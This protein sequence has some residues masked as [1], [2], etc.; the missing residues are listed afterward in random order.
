MMTQTSKHSYPRG[1]CRCCRQLHESLSQGFFKA[2]CDENRLRL[3]VQLAG[4]RTPCTVSQIAECC[5]VDLSVVS[6]HLAVLRDA[7]LIEARKQGK[8]VYYTVR[9]GDVIDT[10]RNVADAIEGCCE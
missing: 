6:R 2:L 4:C 7:G 9:Y 8:E 10:L 3:L 5:P 1:A